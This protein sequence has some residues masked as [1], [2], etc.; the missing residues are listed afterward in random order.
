M[1]YDGSAV[2]IPD[3]AALGKPVLFVSFEEKSADIID[4]GGAIGIEP[5]RLVAEGVLLLDHVAQPSTSTEE[6]REYTLDGLRIRLQVLIQK[7]S[8]IIAGEQGEGS[9]T[10]YGLKESVSD[11]LQGHGIRRNALPPLSGLPGAGKTNVAASLADVFC[12]LNETVLYLSFEESPAEVS[13][14]VSTIGLDFSAHQERGTLHLHSRR[15]ASSGLKQHMVYIYRLLNELQP[16][17]FVINP[18]SSLNSMF[19]TSDV[20]R[21]LVRLT[22][23]L[24]R[25]EITTWVT[26]LRGNEHTDLPINVASFADIWCHLTQIIRKSGQRRICRYARH[27]DSNIKLDESAST[28]ANKVWNF[29]HARKKIYHD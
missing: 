22:N 11:C 26:L 4:R 12:C 6:T 1:V 5:R 7:I 20:Y 3:Q 28:S 2:Q 14:I 13:D 8:L 15:S 18:I 25:A 23:I 16:N 24:K 29:S 17:F 27:V 9:L 19:E 21:T 10:R